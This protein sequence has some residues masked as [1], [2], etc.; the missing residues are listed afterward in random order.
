MVLLRHITVFLAYHHEIVS[1]Q[2][3]KL[4]DRIFCMC[5]M[6]RLCASDDLDLGARTEIQ[7]CWLSTCNCDRAEYGRASGKK[8]VMTHVAHFH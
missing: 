6:A 3:F 1:A 7:A 2:C 5:D 8:P 4:D